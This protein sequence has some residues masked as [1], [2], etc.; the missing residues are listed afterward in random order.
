MPDHRRLLLIS[1]L[2]L[3]TLL[4]IDFLILHEFLPERIPGTPIVISGLF[5]FVCY[6]VLFYTVFKR[7]LKED[8]TIS[9]TYLAIFACLIVLFSEIIF[10]TYR[11]TTFSYITNEDR[12]RIFL[13]GVLGLSAFAGVLALP[14]AVDVKYKN[15]WI[16]TLLNVGVGLAFYFVSPYVLSFIKGE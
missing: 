7:I 10:Q 3:T 15:R 12:I 9:V 13:I 6:E 1:V 16:T 8:D 4:F 5:L 11:L 14:I 2:V